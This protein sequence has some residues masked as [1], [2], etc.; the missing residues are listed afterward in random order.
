MLNANREVTPAFLVALIVGALRAPVAE[1]SSR[2]GFV[3]TTTNLEMFA[4]LS[5][6][7]VAVMLGADR[8][9]VDVDLDG[10]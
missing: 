7:G 9:V 3:W 6:A 4:I 8:F 1:L 2:E 5:V 10:V